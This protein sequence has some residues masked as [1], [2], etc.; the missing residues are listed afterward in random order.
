MT[1]T[2]ISLYY[3]PSAKFW[4]K[5]IK[6]RQT[7]SLSHRRCVLRLRWDTIRSIIL[8]WL[9]SIPYRASMEC[10][11]ASCTS[12]QWT[13]SSWRDRHCRFAWCC[14]VSMTKYTNKVINHFRLQEYIHTISYLLNY[15][16]SLGDVVSNSFLVFILKVEAMF[17]LH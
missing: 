9:S 3:L 17:E 8:F 7:T 14:P 5:F 15:T 10:I 6:E 16:L 12:I 4:C 11:S 2:N 13:F 1:T